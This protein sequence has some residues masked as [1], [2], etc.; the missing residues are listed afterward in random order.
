MRARSSV[1]ICTSVT[2]MLQPRDSFSTFQRVILKVQLRENASAKFTRVECDTLGAYR[3]KTRISRLRYKCI[4]PSS[5]H[6]AS[7]A[8]ITVTIVGITRKTASTEISSI[9]TMRKQPYTSKSSMMKESA[10]AT[11]ICDFAEY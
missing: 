6:P 9:N 3:A 7:V 4:S 8:T 1:D 2:S 11:R 5:L 10:S